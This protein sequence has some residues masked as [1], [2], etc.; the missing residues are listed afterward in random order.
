MWLKL[1]YP[2]IGYFIFTFCS[3][4]ISCWIRFCSLSVHF[5]STPLASAWQHLVDSAVLCLHVLDFHYVLEAVYGAPEVYL[6][7]SWIAVLPVLARMHGPL[8]KEGR[9]T[10]SIVATLLCVDPRHLE[11]GLILV[12]PFETSEAT[13]IDHPVYWKIITCRNL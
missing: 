12:Q 2:V 13:A 10:L 8:A 4:S 1:G 7:H 5:W 3:C 9:V 6:P 11:D